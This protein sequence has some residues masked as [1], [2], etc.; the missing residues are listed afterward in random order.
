MKTLIL[1]RHGKA[2]YPQS[3]Q[4]DH[5]RPLAP[6]GQSNARAQAHH[7]VPSPGDHLLVSDAM[8]TR[9]TTEA[10]L[11]TWHRLGHPHLPELHITPQGYLASA[12]M[13]LDLA[14]MVPDDC[15]VL[16]IVGH[17]PGISDLVFELT[18]EFI[19]MA[20]ADVV[21]IALDIDDW[22]ALAPRCGTVALHRPGRAA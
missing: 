3:G 17:N 19:G 21:H 9:Q 12:E 18:G 22:G 14:A 11:E 10:L 1:M 15:Q 4:R 16:W 7:W 6:R 13:W 8:R 2:E 20:T 5:Q